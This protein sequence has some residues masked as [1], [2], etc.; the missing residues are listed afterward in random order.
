MQRLADY[1]CTFMLHVMT[2]H[3]QS[4]RWI[5]AQAHYLNL[6]CPEG[7][8][9]YASINGLERSKWSRYFHFADELPGK[10]AEK[11]NALAEIVL[12]DASSSDYLLFLDGDAFPIAP[13]D[14]VLNSVRSLV[15]VRREE[16]ARDPQPH[17]SFC[18]TTVGFWRE[19][20]GDWRA[21]YRW[22]N[23]LGR[24]VTDVGGNLLGQL[25]ERGTEWRALTRMNTVDVHPIWFGVY[26]ESELGCVAYHHG[27]GFRRKRTSRGDGISEGFVPRPTRIPASV[28]GLAR[29]ESW[30]RF[31]VWDAQRRVWRRR[32]RAAQ[33]RVERDVY[34]DLNSNDEFW[35]RFVS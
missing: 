5:E 7:T 28:P 23:E 13:I 16:N 29:T 4:P 17:P 22:T 20:A 15:A 27:A 21:G 6:H 31:R 19:I 30:L 14:P 10:H 32:Q 26:G 9:T 35:K 25:L 3:W 8:R 18:V 34:E 12:E 33:L 2:V 24:S 11:L 1:D